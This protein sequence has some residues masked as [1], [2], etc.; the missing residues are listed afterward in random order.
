MRRRK[1]HACLPRISRR[2][3]DARLRAYPHS[4]RA[5]RPLS[6]RK[7]LQ[8]RAQG[9]LLVSRH[10]PGRDPRCKAVRRRARAPFVPGRTRRILRLRG[11]VRLRAARSAPQR[12]WHS[13]RSVYDRRLVRR[14]RCG[15]RHGG[16][17]ESRGE[18]C[19]RR[20]RADDA[21]DRGAQG[22]ASLGRVDRAL[23]SS[24]R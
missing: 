3:R 16:D 5:E 14:V 22:A 10:R 7:R 4:R 6:S 1:A 21:R 9:P 8:R 23:R 13:G 24:R 18:R 15:A 20:L 12:E 11:G 19:A 2:P 17:R